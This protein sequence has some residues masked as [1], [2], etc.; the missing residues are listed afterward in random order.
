M[1]ATTVPDANVTRVVQGTAQDMLQ[2]N[3][4]RAHLRDLECPQ[5]PESVPRSTRRREYRGQ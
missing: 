1:R 3:R 2:K 5:L 4:P